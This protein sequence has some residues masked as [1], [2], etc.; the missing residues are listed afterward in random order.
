MTF[1][2]EQ[3]QRHIDI[4]LPRNVAAVLD[5]GAHKLIRNPSAQGGC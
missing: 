3:I 2:E 1:T 5:H 4:L